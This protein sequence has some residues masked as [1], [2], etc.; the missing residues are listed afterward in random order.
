MI[1]LER[2]R[3]QA[4][5][6]AEAGLAKALWYL[7]GN[8]GKNSSW[9]TGVEGEPGEGP[10]KEELF[11]RK[12]EICQLEI[13]DKGGFLQV[14]STGKSGKSQ[15][16]VSV[17][18]G[19]A[20]TADFNYALVVASPI[21]AVI[22]RGTK[23]KGDVKVKVLPRVEGTLEKDPIVD[24]ALNLPSFDPAA[25]KRT[26]THFRDILTNP[27]KAD[28]ELFSTQVFDEDNKPD[29]SKGP[30]IYVNDSVLFEG[31]SIDSPLVFAGPGTIVSTAD[32]QL[33]GYVR[34]TGDLTL[35][36]QGSIKLFDGAEV[37]DCTLYS[38]LNV[39]LRDESMVTGQIL[40]RYSI[41]V[42][43]RAKVFSP[44]FLYSMSGFIKGQ[45]RGK[46]SILNSA[47]VN[48]VIISSE[49]GGIKE[50]LVF[51]DEDA[52]VNGIIYAQNRSR[53]RGTI[54]GCVITQFLSE[55]SPPPDTT[56]KNEIRGAKIDRRK[57]PEDLA[58]PLGFLKS[59]QFKLI[60]WRKTEG[61]IS[62]IEETPHE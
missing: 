28:Q 29:F 41:T 60:S 43:D 32:I 20:P 54:N 62:S 52:T 37:R 18:L 51:V 23:I 56:L 31:G 4:L 2:D 38:D 8:G 17:I 27:H 24:P 46:I 26:I 12:K 6:T 14:T 16:A 5:Y 30:V 25:M 34:I 50:P 10:Q 13:R 33:S 61:E 53:I 39:E 48:G 22:G 55:E 36:A 15:R 57:M 11:T 47:I 45:P 58:L 21:Q 40:S 44:S 19:V 1:N 59:A 3:L 35:I 9:R 7:K 49:R 42:A